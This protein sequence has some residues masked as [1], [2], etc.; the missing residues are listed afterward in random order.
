MSRIRAN[1]IVNQN[2]NGAPV[3]PKGAVINGISTITADVSLNT[4]QLNGVDA[5][6]SGIG[7]YGVVSLGTGTSIS[8]PSDNVLVLGTNDTEALRITAN[9]DTQVSSGSSLYLANGNLVFSTSGTGIDFSAT[10]DGSGTT[11]SELLDDYEEGTWTATIVGTSSGSYVFTGLCNYVKIGKQVT[12][13]AESANNNTANFGTL[14]GFASI[15]GLPFT[16]GGDSVGIIYYYSYS[17]TGTPYTLIRDAETEIEIRKLE[18]ATSNNQ[19]SGGD[20]DGTNLLRLSI[21]YTI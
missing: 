3:F 7:T 11:T 14:S 13:W 16:A 1:Q 12:V 9:G 17:G 8:S 20:I 21:T 10:S 2:N 4:S 6:F 19:V 15:T 5:N 18:A